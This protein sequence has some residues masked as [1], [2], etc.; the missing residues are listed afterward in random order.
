MFVY[1]SIQDHDWRSFTVRKHQHF[2]IC[3]LRRPNRLPL[4]PELNSCWIDS[5]HKRAK[6]SCVQNMA[7]KIVSLCREGV[8]DGLF[9]TIPSGGIPSG[10]VI[11]A[12]EECQILKGAPVV[13]SRPAIL[14]DINSPYQAATPLLIWEQFTWPIFTFLLLVEQRAT[15]SC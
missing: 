1:G 5:N 9:V 4:I 2:G 13:I 15:T 10:G 12:M 6:Q 7:S 8:H 3:P 14:I 11:S